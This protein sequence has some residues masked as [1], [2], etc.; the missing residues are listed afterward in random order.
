[1]LRHAITVGD[2]LAVAGLIVC[3]L[4]FFVG[5]VLMLGGGFVPA[6]GESERRMGR[7][8]CAVIIISLAAGGSIFWSL[9][10]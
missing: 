8:G 2:L 10:P 7:A 1:M 9:V 4:G 5:L 3:I 6:P